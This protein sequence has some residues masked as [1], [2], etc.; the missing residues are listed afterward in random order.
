MDILING[1]S[2]TVPD[3]CTVSELL[4]RQGAGGSPCAVEVNRRLV[5]KREHAAH[6]LAEGDRVEVVTLVGGG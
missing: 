2:M 3:G 1:E 6:Q 4:K 5:P